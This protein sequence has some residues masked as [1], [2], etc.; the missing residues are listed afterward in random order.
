MTQRIA[1][2]GNIGEVTYYIQT[3]DRDEAKATVIT[4]NKTEQ[5]I[6]IDWEYAERWVERKVKA[7]EIGRF[8]R[9]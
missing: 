7:Y 2:A 6:L 9:E 8:T 1:A 5:E 3:E 4:P